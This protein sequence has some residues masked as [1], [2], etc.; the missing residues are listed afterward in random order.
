[1]SDVQRP[2]FF[3]GQ[4]IA[5]ADLTGTV[6]H[7]RVRDARHDR[8]LHEWGI[9]EGLSL[10]AEPQTDPATN[11]R[12]VTVTLQPGMAIDGTGREIVVP[13]PVT[14]QEAQFQEVN[15]ADRDDEIVLYPV[16]LAG[17]DRDPVPTSPVPD[18]CGAN[19]QRSRVDESYQILCG[20]LGDER[21]V[22]DQQPPPVDA[23]PGDGSEPWLILLGYVTWA[24]DRFQ[25]VAVS[26]NGVGIR[27]A[28]VRA[29]TV[30]ARSGT[31]ALR[32]ALAAAEGGPVV[33]LDAAAGL[34]F[35]LYKGDGSVD[36]LL[37]VST[38]GDVTVRG[39]IAIGQTGGTVTAV[40]GVATDGVILPLPAGVTADQ[41]ADGRV[42]LHTL[43]SARLATAP[44]PPNGGVWMT[45]PFDCTVD[46]Q[47]RVRCR[48]RKVRV[49]S[50]QP[51][52]HDQPA[53][54]DFVVLATVVPD[55]EASGG[56]GAS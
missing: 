5:A 53:A 17:L 51:D 52:W 44:D 27:Y 12:F 2:A 13:E 50:A 46:S 23:G 6:D 25:S 9:A 47:R 41:V 3:E 11:A 55:P 45:A 43:V 28:G 49:D 15:G 10:T 20:R 33:T 56:S 14:L 8:Y 32:S 54:V 16:F 38:R 37:T 29:D 19:G 18:R 40:S 22:A 21:L 24:A 39:N 34:A 36:E 4:V 48:L 30:A 1:M 31:L 35:G 7:A 42:A 26:A